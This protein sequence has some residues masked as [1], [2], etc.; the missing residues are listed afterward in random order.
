MAH[1]L[2]HMLTIHNDRVFAG[3]KPV[4]FIASPNVGGR[5][6][7]V[8]IVVHDTAGP[9]AV[10]AINTFKSPASKVSAHFVVDLDGTITQMVECDRVA[11]H[12]GK[13]VLDGR[14][15]CNGFTVGIEI[16]NPGKL[17]A[18]G[19][20]WFHKAGQPGYSDTQACTTKEHGSG[21]WLPYT[22]EQILAV[23][24]L[25]RAIAKAYP[26]IKQ[27]VP[28]W[29]I[30]PGRKVDTNPLFPLAELRQAVFQP[31]S[32]PV[33]AISSLQ[34]GSEGRAL[35]LAYKRLLEL[36][37]PV[38][39]WDG[40][41]GAVMETAVMGFERQNGLTV[42]GKLDASEQVILHSEK[43]KG[44]PIAARE[45]VSDKDLA[46]A[47]RGVSDL[48]KL[49]QGGLFVTTASAAAASVEQ[50]TAPAVVAPPVAAPDPSVIEQLSQGAEGAGYAKTIAE[51]LGGLLS[52]LGSN[53][54]VQLMVVG[55]AA[56]FVATRLLGFRREDFR[57]G[58]WTPSGR[59]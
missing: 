36:G 37:Y 59:Q 20:A 11:W 1:G 3:S 21:H 13:S 5:M 32:A 51:S 23:T 55:I 30:S 57:L 38:G 12:A 47:S 48:V 29:Y 14:S 19:C 58:R 54:Y 27:I 53:G 6:Q 34:V 35:E 42:D 24:D 45:S 41:F 7:P 31:Q 22:P 49:K 4:P 52:A 10:S 15:G 17:D 9:S 43:A 50:A 28:H 44:M 16:V 18:K 46:A 25:C 40:V 33:A 39:V 26:T 56:Y 2:N 8:A